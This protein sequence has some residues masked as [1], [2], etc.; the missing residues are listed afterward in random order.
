[1]TIQPIQRLSVKDLVSVA[2]SSSDSPWTAVVN[3]S[4]HAN[5][6]GAITITL[7][8]NF[9]IGDEIEV[10]DENYTSGTN[11]ITLDRNGNTIEGAASNFILDVD[12]GI[13]LV[14]GGVGDWLLDLGGV[15]I[16]AKGIIRLEC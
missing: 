11:N 7:P 4:I 14:K 16:I 13:V 9:A 8:A 15:D 2:I 5:A 6:D 10:I 1:M 12:G 3:T